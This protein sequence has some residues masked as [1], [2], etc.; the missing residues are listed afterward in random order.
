MLTW[1]Y[2]GFYTSEDQSST[3]NLVL[4]E[5]AKRDENRLVVKAVPLG[6]FYSAGDYSP[7]YMGKYRGGYC[8]QH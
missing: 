3:V 6:D 7:K 5:A 8:L 2:K 4:D 1:S